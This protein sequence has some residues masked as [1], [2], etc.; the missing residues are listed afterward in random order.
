MSLNLEF[1]GML[2]NHPHFQLFFFIYCSFAS[3][4]LSLKCSQH[5]SFFFLRRLQQSVPR[6]AGLI[7]ASDDDDALLGMDVETLVKSAYQARET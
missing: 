6:R 5:L 7:M 2:G 4:F 1:L 3:R